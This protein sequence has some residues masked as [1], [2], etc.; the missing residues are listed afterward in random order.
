MMLWMPMSVCDSIKF[1]AEPGQVGTG[2]LD[3]P[4]RMRLNGRMRRYTSHV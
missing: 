3:A 1:I 4:V 2:D